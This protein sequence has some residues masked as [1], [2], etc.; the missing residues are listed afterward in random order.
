MGHDVWLFHR[1]DGKFDGVAF[2]GRISSNSC[3]HGRDPVWPM[4]AI[5]S[6]K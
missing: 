2:V 3:G 5:A 6:K 1:A 4:P